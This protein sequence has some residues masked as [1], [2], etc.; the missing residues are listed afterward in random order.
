MKNIAMIVFLL[1]VGGV[2]FIAAGMAVLRA[3]DVLGDT[4]D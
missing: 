2:V 3:L 4:Y 1:W